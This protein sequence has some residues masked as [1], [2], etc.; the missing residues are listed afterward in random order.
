[1]GLLYRL[2]LNLAHEEVAK[3]QEEL[4]IAKE[5]EKRQTEESIEAMKIQ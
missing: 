5:K 1:M 2:G 4:F 3:L